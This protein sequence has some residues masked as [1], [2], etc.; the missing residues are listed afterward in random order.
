MYSDET[1]YVRKSR[2]LD[3][4]RGMRN[5]MGAGECDWRVGIYSD[6]LPILVMG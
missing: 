4:S 5:V 2:R 3:P 1:S 6:N